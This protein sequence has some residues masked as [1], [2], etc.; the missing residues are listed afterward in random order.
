MAWGDEG[1]T[2]L[3]Y[4]SDSTTAWGPIGVPK[5]VTLT[6]AGIIRSLRLLQG[7]GALTL[8][9]GAAASLMGPYNAYQQLELLANSQ[10]DIFRVSGYGMYLINCLKNGLEEEGPPPNATMGSP[11]NVTD[12]D[13]IFDGRAINAPVTN[14]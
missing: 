1:V 3:Q 11:V 12:Q 2:K 5:T 6:K 10:Q 13:F 4:K 7:G 9:A 14:I 8:G